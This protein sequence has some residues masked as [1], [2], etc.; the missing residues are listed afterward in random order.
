MA[1]LA[2]RSGGFWRLRRIAVPLGYGHFRDFMLSTLL[3]L[4]CVLPFVSTMCLCVGQPRWVRRAEGGKL[5][6]H[7]PRGMYI[8]MIVLIFFLAAA[9]FMQA[10]SFFSD[11]TH[12]AQSEGELV[13]LM[14]LPY[15][16]I[17]W[18]LGAIILWA[19]TPQETRINLDQRTY[20]RI[21]GWAWRRRVREGSLDEMM[22]ICITRRGSVMLV[23][24]HWSHGSQRR[25]IT[26]GLFIVGLSTRDLVRISLEFTNTMS[27][28]LQVPFIDCP[29]E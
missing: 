23:F 27:G 24:K 11:K 3:I 1:F 26:L 6:V 29:W 25:G 28:L 17:S 4:I 2:P 13:W 9:P 12:S 14:L 18:G 16:G 10:F 22:G 21:E 7:P 8:G 15:A 5:I 20:E 19:I